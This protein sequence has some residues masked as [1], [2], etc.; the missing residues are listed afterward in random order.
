MIIY[1][2]CKWIVIERICHV[3]ESFVQKPVAAPIV[4]L[5]VRKYECF[6]YN[7]L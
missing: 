4:F 3:P 1:M 5:K 2:I 6:D 7:Y